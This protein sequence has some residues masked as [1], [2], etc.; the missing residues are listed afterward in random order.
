MQR[1]AEPGALNKWQKPLGAG[2][3]RAVTRPLSPRRIERGWM[4]GAKKMPCVVVDGNRLR[5]RM[6]VVPAR[7]LRRVTP[8]RISSQGG[9]GPTVNL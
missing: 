8:A 9:N 1:W 7:R 6:P 2:R 4:V 5:R 3:P